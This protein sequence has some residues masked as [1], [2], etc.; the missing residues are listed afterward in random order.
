M[1]SAE[2]VIA[3]CTA[4]LTSAVTILAAA[5]PAAAQHVAPSQEHATVTR[6]AGGAT[7]RIT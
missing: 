1:W 7:A 3:A 5:Q 6:K 2:H 4:I